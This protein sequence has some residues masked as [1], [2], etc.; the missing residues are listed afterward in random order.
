VCSKAARPPRRSNN[1]RSLV[2]VAATFDVFALAGAGV[3]VFAFD[4]VAAFAAPAIFGP[5]SATKPLDA[6][7]VDVDDA[8]VADVTFDDDGAANFG[9]STATKPSLTFVDVDDAGAAAATD[10]PRDCDAQPGQH[11]HTADDDLGAVAATDVGETA[12]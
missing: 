11:V 9:P 10:A 4:D 6:A 1:E 2:D 5:S 8:L 3:A 7:P 12:A